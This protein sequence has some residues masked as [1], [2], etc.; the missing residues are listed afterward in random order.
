MCALVRCPDC[1]KPRI[2][3]C[4]DEEHIESL[5]RVVVPENQCKCK[6]R[7]VAEIRLELR[8]VRNESV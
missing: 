1:L 5:A 3:G 6:E 8:A 2:I 7:I 4:D